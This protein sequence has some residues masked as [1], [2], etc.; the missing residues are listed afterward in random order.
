MGEGEGGVFSFF[1]IK[2]FLPVNAP[3]PFGGRLSLLVAATDDPTR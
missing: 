2:W 3:P 1:N